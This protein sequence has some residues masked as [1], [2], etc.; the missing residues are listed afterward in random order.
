[1]IVI[2]AGPEHHLITVS[3]GAVVRGRLVEDGKPVGN[4]EVGLIGRPRGGY[5]PN[6]LLSG[7][8]YEE[9]RNRNTA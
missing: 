8:P 4:A 3:D 6:L 7:Y 9:V 5:G 1:M 2:P